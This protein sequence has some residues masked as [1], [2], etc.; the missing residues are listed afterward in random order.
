M[1]VIGEGHSSKKLSTFS[2]LAMARFFFHSSV[3]RPDLFLLRRSC[4]FPWFSFPSA[5]L[6]FLLGGA[7]SSFLPLLLFHYFRLL[8]LVR[9]LIL[10][11]KPQANPTVPSAGTFTSA[12]HLASSPSPHLE[13][14]L[15]WKLRTFSRLPSIRFTV[16]N[17]LLKSSK[18][19]TGGCDI[20]TIMYVAW[21]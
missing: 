17:V 13:V 9:F 11:P 6:I 19:G 2:T 1:T 5:L 7:T 14:I 21:F 8:F 16:G 20:V 12:V 4:F 18:I 10:P 3:T 15:M